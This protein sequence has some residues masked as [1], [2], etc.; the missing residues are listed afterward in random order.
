MA[1]IHI[2]PYDAYVA[3]RN[4]EMAAFVDVRSVEEYA[5]GHAKGFTN[6]PL[7]EIARD[8]SHIPKADAVYFMCYSGGRSFL[9]AKLALSHGLN[10]MNIEGGFSAWQKAGL[11]VE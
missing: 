5:R 6:I 2:S 9:A 4:P 10:T 1:T 11:P 7:D 3:Q 8:I